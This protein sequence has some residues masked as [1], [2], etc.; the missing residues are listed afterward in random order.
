MS[1]S[2]FTS[3][4]KTYDMFTPK[5]ISD[6]PML[7]GSDTNIIGPG[8]VIEG[9]LKA[10]SDIRVDGKVKGYIN[11]SSKIVVGP[12]GEVEGDMVCRNADILGRV[13]GTIKVEELLILKAD[14]LINGDV[15]TGQ[16]EMEPTAKF[17]GRCQMDQQA[18]KEIDGPQHPKPISFPEEERV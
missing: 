9:D 4:P 6:E 5:K 1:N 17:N 7:P 13:T 14:G 11:T 3:K 2:F 16:F 10:N 18:R 12:G 8:T 15:F